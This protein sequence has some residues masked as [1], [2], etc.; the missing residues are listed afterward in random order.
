M[1]RKARQNDIEAVLDIIDP[2]VN[3]GILLKKTRQDI[4]VRIRDFF[5]YEDENEIAGCAALFPGWDGLGEICTLAVRES[6]QKKGIGTGLVKACI[7]DGRD[8][9]LPKIF[10]LT[11]E[12]DFFRGQGFQEIDKHTLPQK[13]FKDC[14]KCPHYLDCNE[15]A[16]IMEL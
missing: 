11:Y 6:M 10:T 1:L 3:R 9:G 8:L 4:V 12:K 14:I 15:T 16:M 2:Y 5:V 7:E 13:I